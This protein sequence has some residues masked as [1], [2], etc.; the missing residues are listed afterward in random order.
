MARA[1]ATS[2]LPYWC[3]E[4]Y[5]R[6]RLKE[7]SQDCAHV[8]LISR[9]LAKDSSLLRFALGSFAP[10]YA[11]FTLNAHNLNLKLQIMQQFV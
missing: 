6:R 9:V 8:L 7:A 5:M 2:C 11:F 3:L 1:D 10:G 4:E